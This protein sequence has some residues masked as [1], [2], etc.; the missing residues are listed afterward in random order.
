MN[1]EGYAGSYSRITDFL[2]A[3]RPDGGQ[4]VSDRAFVPLAFELSGPFHCNWSEEGLVERRAL[5]TVAD[6]DVRW[7]PNETTS[8]SLP[9]TAARNWRIANGK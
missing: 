4:S 5:T 2:R 3:W 8:D 7:Q 9:R 6:I 1:A